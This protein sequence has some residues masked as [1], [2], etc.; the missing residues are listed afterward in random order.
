MNRKFN[1]QAADTLFDELEQRAANKTTFNWQ[2]II[3]Q[4]L[5]SK[6]DREMP[7]NRLQKKVLTEFEAR[8]G[9]SATDVKVITKFN[10]ELLKIPGLVIQKD[11][12]KLTQ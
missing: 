1:A 7:L 3:L 4:V 5:E 9:G 2:K 6:E 11:V 10:K 8:G 12:A